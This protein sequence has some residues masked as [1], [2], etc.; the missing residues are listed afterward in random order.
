[1]H[2]AT[3][4]P[5]GLGQLL[6]YTWLPGIFLG[7]H[8]FTWNMGARLTLAGNATLVVNMIP[9]VMPILMYIMH[10]IVPSRRELLG[11]GVAMAGVGILGVGSVQIS[12]ESAAG[13]LL[14][15]VAMVFLALYLIFAKTAQG[16]NI[17]LLLYLTMVYMVGSLT[18]FVINLPFA[19][20][21]VDHLLPPQLWYI[22]GLTLVPTVLGHSLLNRAMQ[23]LPSQVVSIG[24]LS[25]FIWAALLAFLAFG[26]IPE[27]VF[28]PASVFVL[29][30]AGIT[31]SAHRKKSL[32][33]KEKQQ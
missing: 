31:L 16:V 10:R 21:A 26:E 27:P 4:R 5:P 30:G 25:Q 32:V 15:F 19:P 11:S 28:Y 6:R 12:P 7:L 14:C 24:Q 13:D 17:P 1:M 23:T 20:P 9:L 8:F 29:I 33:V 18:A 22:L 3:S 2:E